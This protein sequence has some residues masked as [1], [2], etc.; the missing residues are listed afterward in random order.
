MDYRLTMAN[1]FGSCLIRTSHSQAMLCHYTYEMSYR[2]LSITFAHLRY[3]LAGYPPSQT[4]L[5]RI[6]SAAADMYYIS[7]EWYFTLATR[8]HI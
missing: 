4:T 3:Y 7:T 8:S 1:L 6:N 2:H 5:C